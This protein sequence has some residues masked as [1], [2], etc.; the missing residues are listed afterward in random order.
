M[1][2][3][4]DCMLAA[5]RRRNRRIEQPKHPG[6][7]VRKH[8]GPRAFFFSPAKTF[9]SAIRTA[10]TCQAPVRLQYVSSFFSSSRLMFSWKAIIAFL[11]CFLLED[12]T[13]STALARVACLQHLPV[14]ESPE[15]LLLVGMLLPLRKSR[16]P[17]ER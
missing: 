9:S 5:K 7:V 1:S 10:R 4:D 17:C 13:A 11:S 3:I 8:P 16:Q 14:T 12:T 2:L 6:Q 15:H